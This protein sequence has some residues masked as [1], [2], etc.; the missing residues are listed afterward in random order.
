MIPRDDGY[1]L[2]DTYTETFIDNNHSAQ[3]AAIIVAKWIIDGDLS[4]TDI[5]EDFERHR[6]FVEKH[7]I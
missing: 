4:A 3:H 5:F 1:A 7:K 6:A 2:F